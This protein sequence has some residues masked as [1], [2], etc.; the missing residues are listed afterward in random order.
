MNKKT[1]TAVVSALVLVAASLAHALGYQFS[2]TLQAET[3]NYVYILI[4]SVSG[5]VAVLSTVRA[6][7]AAPLLL[8]GLMC[9][10]GCGASSAFYHT[11]KETYPLIDEEYRLYVMED[12]T[13]GPPGEL[14][15]DRVNILRTADILKQAIELEGA[16]HAGE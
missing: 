13:L 3:Q 6:S 5:L 12:P 14:T 4:E 1:V 9:V 7:R 15:E 8:A 16:K 10:G 2:E 11:V